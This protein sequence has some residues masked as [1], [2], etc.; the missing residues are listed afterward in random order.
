MKRFSRRRRNIFIAMLLGF[1]TLALGTVLNTGGLGVLPPRQ[2]RGLAQT[3]LSNT[4]N[5]WNSTLTS[6]SPNAVAA[7]VWDY[8]GVDTVF[9]TAVL[10]ASITGLSALFRGAIE[11]SGLGVRGM[12][13]KLKTSTKIII[14]LTILVSIS[15]AVH[16]HLTPGGGF[17][18]G[19]IIAVATALGITVFS[20]ESLYGVG[21]KSKSLLKL[22]FTALVLIIAT[23]LTP[24]VTSLF[25]GGLAYIMQNQLKE[26]S[27]FS[28]PPTFFT[29]PIAGT[30]FFF[31]LFEF[32]AVGASLS[33]ALLIFTM[34]REEVEHIFEGG[35]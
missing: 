30:I 7:V 26:G 27:T 1:L 20:I 22:R 16:G 3:V 12:S 8:R 13:V 28:A 24:L 10:F 35:S 17:Q 5:P 14:L 31:N 19:S 29:T 33:Y 2:L 6:Y 25:T 4:Y 21:L 32:I 9:E 23:A 18:A 34:R 11:R 15:L